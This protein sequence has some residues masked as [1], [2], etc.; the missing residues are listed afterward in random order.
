MLLLPS[1]GFL[2]A[3]ASLGHVP[4]LM[5]VPRGQAAAVT[6]VCSGPAWCGPRGYTRSPRS[7]F[8]SESLHSGLGG[9]AGS[10]N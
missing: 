4:H 8:I 5:S 10:V 6:S 3:L 2:L 7:A 9:M 1:E